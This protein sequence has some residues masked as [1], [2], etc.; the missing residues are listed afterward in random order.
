MVGVS[1]WDGWRCEQMWWVGGGVSGCG[2]WGC[3][4]MWEKGMKYL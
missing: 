4:W 2:G 1:G 3:E